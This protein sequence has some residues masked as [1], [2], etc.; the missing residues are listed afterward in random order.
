MT[1]QYHFTDETLQDLRHIHDASEFGPRDI[2]RHVHRRE[3][4]HVRA[5]ED[6]AIAFYTQY[7]R[8]FGERY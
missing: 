5:V 2:Y 6:L 4:Q 7:N 3:P 1:A 8:R